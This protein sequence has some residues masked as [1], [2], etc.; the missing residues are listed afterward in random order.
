MNREKWE[1]YQPP[2]VR[3]A[4]LVEEVGEV[5]EAYLDLMDATAKVGPG[6]LSALTRRDHLLEELEHVEFQAR[7]FREQVQ[8]VVL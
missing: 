3:L 8:N 4:K 2:P 6:S 1:K 5:A 7:C